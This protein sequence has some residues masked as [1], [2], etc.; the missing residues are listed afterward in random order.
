MRKALLASAV[1]AALVAGTVAV[2]ARAEQNFDVT[3]NNHRVTVTAHTGWHINQAYPW[4]L[5][6]GNVKLD[7]SHFTLQKE[8][9][10]V[11]GAPDGKGKIRGAVCSPS[12][13]MPFSYDVVIH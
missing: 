7:K 10:S 11:N 2:T 3:V 9:A 12:T 4:K 1:V 5:V 13:C 8:T 6:V